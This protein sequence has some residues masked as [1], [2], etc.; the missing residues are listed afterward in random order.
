M[1]LSYAKI[2]KFGSPYVPQWNFGPVFQLG[3]VIEIWIFKKN[4]KMGYVLAL[5]W[6]NVWHTIEMFDTYP[7][8]SWYKLLENRRKSWNNQKSYFT[9]LDKNTQK[10]ILW[11]VAKSIN[12]EVGINVEGGIFWKKLV[13]K[14]NK[15]G[16]EGGK[17]LSNQ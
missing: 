2:V 15:R 11:K 16:V 9:I 17:N 13:Y 10:R 7:E 6:S 5:S 12:V 3:P 4:C 8:S 1:N 14:C